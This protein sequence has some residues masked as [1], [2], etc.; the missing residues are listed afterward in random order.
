[1]SI[2]CGALPSQVPIEV[3]AER[4][5][6]AE[7]PGNL[8]LV[9]YARESGVL[10]LRHADVDD[11]IRKVR[12]Q[13][14]AHRFVIRQ[15]QWQGTEELVRWSQGDGVAPC[16]DLS[17]S[18]DELQTVMY[19]RPMG[20]DFLYFRL[21]SPARDLGPKFLAH[22]YDPGQVAALK[23][24]MSRWRQRHLAI[25]HLA[26]EPLPYLDKPRGRGRPKP[27]CNEVEYCICGDSGT[28][29]WNLATRTTTAIRK[30]MRDLG[31]K[32]QLRDAM[33]VLNLTALTAE[34]LDDLCDEDVG[35]AVEDCSPDMLDP[36]GFALVGLLY[37]SPLR[38]TLR[39]A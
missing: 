15:G 5:A 8:A 12:Q 23:G 9:P 17:A 33:V 18:V 19:P 4:R 24:V 30:A 2:L 26:Q 14:S 27:P 29:L 10:A 35:I 36:A 39:C 32:Q 34:A 7:S 38:P 20:S 37:E 13:V 22:K 6:A 25:E 31:V 11:A 3:E 1:M 16:A 21:S 28:K